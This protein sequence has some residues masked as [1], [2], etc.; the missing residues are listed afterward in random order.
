MNQ[1]FNLSIVIPCYNEGKRLDTSSFIEFLDNQKDT[2]ICFVDDGSKDNT[3]EV[4]NTIKHKFP[5]SVEVVSAV[6]NEGKAAAVKTGVL[7]CTQ[8]IK[9][10]KIAY[11]DADLATSLEECVEIS[12][13]IN[14]E[15]VFA[16]GSRISKIDNYI[17]RK[18]YRFLIGRII[19]TAISHQLK[20]PVYDTQCGCK[21]FTNN[22]AKEIFKD[23]FISKWLFD[24]EIFHRISAIYGTHK[25]PTICKE[26]PLKKWVDVGESKVHITYFFKLWLDL[27]KIGKTYKNN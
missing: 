17:D 27:L 26:I 23:N 14:S 25:M 22:L 8:K 6:K 7:F 24:V 5:N 10:N 4:L 13:E 19:A 9:Q 20:L 11:I 12:S 16:F 3:L 1:L 21:I 2:L 15:I 18:L